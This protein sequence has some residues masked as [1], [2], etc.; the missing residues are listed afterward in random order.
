MDPY[1]LEIPERKRSEN[2]LQRK[3]VSSALLARLRQK[4]MNPSSRHT[5]R[6]RWNTS[7]AEQAALWSTSNDVEWLMVKDEAQR[8][9]VP[10]H[11]VSIAMRELV[12]EGLLEG[13]TYVPHDVKGLRVNG[14]LIKHD[15]KGWVFRDYEAELMLGFRKQ[16]RY[17]QYR[18]R[19]THP[20]KRELE[21]FLHGRRRRPAPWDGRGF[22][23]LSESRAYQAL[24]ESMTAAA[25]T[26]LCPMC[27]TNVA[28]A[29]GRHGRKRVS[30]HSIKKCRMAL[31]QLIL[32]A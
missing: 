22:R 2:H 11:L 12:K 8:I 16:P 19:G 14:R 28:R 15:G 10:V 4:V 26:I 24:V 25:P 13:P 6:I 21:S 32:N 27:H 23:I 1:E 18:P 17:G 30:H 3:P 7:R 5:D 20:S 9:G 29:M 31:V